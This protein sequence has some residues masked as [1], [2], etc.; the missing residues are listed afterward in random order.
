[1][2]QGEVVRM[3]EQSAA[4]LSM[5]LLVLVIVALWAVARIDAVVRRA[6]RKLDI[7]MKC[8]GYNPTQIATLE[9]QALVRA[10]RKAEAVRV[11]R[12]L[13]GASRAEA[14]ATIESF[15]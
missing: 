14:V 13:T 2:W 5:F 12:E 15:S 8:S 3:P 7:L 4:W 6:E 10:G 11:Y 1:M 9:A